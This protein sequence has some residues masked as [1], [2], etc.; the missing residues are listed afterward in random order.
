MAGSKTKPTA[1]SVADFVAA[2]P[3]ETRRSDV[4]QMIAMLSA[5]TGEPAYMWGPTM[6]GF[7]T[8][9]YVYESGREGDAP[10]VSLASRA[11]DLVLYL[12]EDFPERGPLLA[13]LGKH[14]LGK[15]CLYIRKLA[16]IDAAVLEAL[17]EAS[18]AALR[19]R[20]PR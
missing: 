20:Y 18:S 1:A 2:M 4:R 17:V 11:S 10:L 16:D 13:R 5:M 15:S 7:G 3:D 9:H 14:K 6:I 19:R 12:C 8:Y